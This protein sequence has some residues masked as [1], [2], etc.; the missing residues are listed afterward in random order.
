MIVSEQK[1]SAKRLLNMLKTLVKKALMGGHIVAT[2]RIRLNH[3]STVAMRLMSNYFDQ[4]LSL[5]TPT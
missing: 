2:W 3:L 5:G 1:C 4:L